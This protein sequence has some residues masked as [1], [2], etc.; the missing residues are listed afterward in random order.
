[1]SR[2]APVCPLN[3]AELMSQDNTLGSYHL[4]LAH[5]VLHSNENA[6]RYRRVYVHE[7]NATWHKSN[8]TVIMDNSVV[9]LGHAMPYDD[10]MQA[11]LVVD[12][13]YIVAQDSFLKC[14]ETVNAAAAF[15]QQHREFLK[16]N[17]QPTEK[18]PKLLGVIQGQTIGEV[19]QCAEFYASN[20]EFA[21]ISVPRCLQPIFGSR[22]KPL[23]ELYRRYHDR[24]ELWHLLG[25]SDNVIDDIACARLPFVDGIDSAAP[26]RAAMHR[27]KFELSTIWSA[28][29]RGRFWETSEAEALDGQGYLRYNMALLKQLLDT[30]PQ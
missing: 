25:F 20:P 11:A 30:N 6:G 3:I 12:A 8:R 28:G 26:I 2:F 19:L 9:E 29:P 23:M 24:F 22:M 17:G 4:L 7:M 1:M 16:R 5:D 18:I 10:V 13:D 27:Q 14:A 21:A 15:L